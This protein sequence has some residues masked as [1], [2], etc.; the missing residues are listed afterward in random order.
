M[1]NEQQNQ[2]FLGVL[3]GGRA[4]AKAIGRD[5]AATYKALECGHIPGARKLGG[6]WAL[7]VSEFHA[8]FAPSGAAA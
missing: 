8:A 3:W 1:P 4:I 6:K 2:N 5:E 7:N